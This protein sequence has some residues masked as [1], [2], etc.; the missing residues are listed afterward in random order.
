MEVKLFRTLFASSLLMLPLIGPAQANAAAPVIR[1]AAIALSSCTLPEVAQVARCGVLHVPE[2]PRRPKGRRLPIHV[3]VIPATN[4]A[5]L[6]DPIVPIMGGPGEDAIGAAA[7]FAGQFALLRSNRDLL[8]VDQ[9]GTGQSAAL[10]CDLYSSRNVAA[11]LRDLFPRAAVNRCERQLR[12]RAD[13]TQ[14]GY[15]RFA[16][17][18]EQ[19]RR[20]LG[21]GPLNLSAGS[22]GTRAAV[23]YLRA[24]PK[25]V[26]TAYLGSVVPID[27]AQPLPMAKTA[28]AALES[29]LDGCAVDSVCHDAFP[30]LSAEFDKV[31]AR[32]SSG[33]QVSIPGSTD[34]AP[35]ERG[36]VAEWFR[37]LLYR[38][39]SAAPLPWLIHQAYL[40][41]WNPIVEGILSQA[42]NV[43]SNLSLGLLFAITCNEDLPF[44]DEREVVQQTRGTFLGDYRV[45]QQQ[46]ACR[47]WPKSV[48]PNKYRSPVHSSVPTMFVSGDA[49]GGT[50]LWFMQ[51]AAT[52]FTE[53]VEIVAGGQG[54]TEWSDCIA[55]LY[56][57]FVSDGSTRALLGAT[58]ESVPRPSFKTE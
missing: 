49:D 7:I 6:S 1:P 18:L 45:R 33:V 2:D 23:V 27:V 39:K 26:R 17:D 5:A 37:S 38:P 52:G 50:P 36:R 14:Y 30:N 24:Y 57:R 47:P 51:H 35:L 43:D 20:A 48:L 56:Q 13:L 9:R 34:I 46:T 12:T 41:N 16:S 44:L 58:C 19:V 21:Y 3:A 54:H 55:R 8:L 40:N 29:I 15:L 42:R 25:S 53:H 31:V 28:Q 11:S 22:Y 4:G 10:H 32:L